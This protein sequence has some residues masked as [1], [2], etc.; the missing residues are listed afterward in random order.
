MPGGP[1]SPEADAQRYGLLPGHAAGQ[2]SDGAAAGSGG[3]RVAL[4]G[5]RG[6]RARRRGL[7]VGA[8]PAAALWQQL[9][10]RVGH[11]VLALPAE[12]VDPALVVDRVEDVVLAGPLRRRGGAAE[13]EEV[14]LLLDLPVGRD[15]QEAHAVLVLRDGHEAAVAERRMLLEPV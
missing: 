13:R 5:L 6:V 3:L 7:A 9:A 1:S 10:G 11:V 2:S 12:D 4:C 15:L 8:A 14:A